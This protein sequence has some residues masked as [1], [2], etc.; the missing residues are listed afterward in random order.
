MAVDIG[1]ALGKYGFSAISG[2]FSWFWYIGLGIVIA[3]GIF[4]IWWWF[5]Y[6][7]R[8]YYYEPIGGL[9]YPKQKDESD[10]E[11]KQRIDELLHDIDLT[12]PKKD[13]GKYIKFRGVQYFKIRNAFKKMKP[14]PY[15]LRYP[16]GIFSVRVDKDTFIPIRRPRLDDQGKVTLK[17]QDEYDTNFF[18]LMMA[19]EMNMKYRDEDREKKLMVL[20]IVIVVGGLLLYGLILWLSYLVTTKQIEE[21]DGLT[22]AISSMSAKLTGGGVAP[23]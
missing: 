13:M 21:V 11:Y 9:H 18:N 1:A 14:V 19:D 6:N 16:D 5:S 23:G 7:K 10:E 12:N 4:M 17:I 15:E 22:S 20:F 2:F 8:F 3:V